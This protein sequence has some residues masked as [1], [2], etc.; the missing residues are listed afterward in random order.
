MERRK[1]MSLIL[2]IAVLFGFSA[3]S[4]TKTV[5][6]STETA[7]ASAEVEEAVIEETADEIE[8]APM[9][10]DGDP[11]KVGYMGL[12]ESS[13][14][15]KTVR[16]SMVYYSEQKGI[17]L[18]VVVTD[19][20]PA[21]MGAAMD[22]FVLQ[23]VDF[24]VDGNNTVELGAHFAALAKEEG[25]PY[26]TVDFEAG[27][28]YFFG[29]N[30]QI[31]GETVAAAAARMIIDEWDGDVDLVVR[32]NWPG[33]GEEVIKRSESI[34]EALAENGIDMSDVDIALLTI[35]NPAAY[36]TEK[37]MQ[38][39]TDL[40]N[41]HPDAEKI[42]MFGIED[43]GAA[44]FVSVAQSLGRADQLMAFG[45]DTTDSA[46]HTLC[47]DADSG[48][49]SPFRG[50]VNTFVQYYGDEITDIVIRVL[51]GEEVDYANYTPM[52]LATAENI[53]SMFP[54]C[55]RDFFK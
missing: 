21:K 53:Y 6:L 48:T 41:S 19:G 55:S 25:I 18:T 36:T 27:A 34:P 11:I 54:D 26:L 29:Y 23:G 15:W 9:S 10:A 43:S 46:L 17:D 28:D 35:E 45:V 13:Q 50:S 24:I 2:V 14:F 1:V 16:D 31:L 12:T 4:Q 52:E 20:D 37:I 39:S 5:D 30:N 8:K 3:C 38:K 7:A 44:A 49:V 42:V 51:N 40:L 32:I 22:Q 47:T 33:L